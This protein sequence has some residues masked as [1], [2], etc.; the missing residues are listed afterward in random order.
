MPLTAREAAQADDFIDRM[1]RAA[2]AEATCHG[3]P[4]EVATAWHLAYLRDEYPAAFLLVRAR[5]GATE[6]SAILAHDTG[7][8]PDEGNAYAH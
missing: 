1:L 2:C 7:G 8:L 6:C 5:L 3:T 4:I